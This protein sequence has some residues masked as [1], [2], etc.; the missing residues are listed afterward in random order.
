MNATLAKKNARGMSEVSAQRLQILGRRCQPRLPTAITTTKRQEQVLRVLANKYQ[1]LV[2]QKTAIIHWLKKISSNYIFHVV[3][4]FFRRW[5]STLLSFYS[6]CALAQENN[7]LARLIAREKSWKSWTD[8]IELFVRDGHKWVLV[9]GLTFLCFVSF[10]FF[11][12][13]TFGFAFRKHGACPKN[14]F[15]SIPGQNKNLKLILDVQ[16]LPPRQCL[17]KN[18]LSWKKSPLSSK[19]A[20]PEEPPKT[21]FVPPAE[22]TCMPP[23]ICNISIFISPSLFKCPSWLFLTFG[24]EFSTKNNNKT[25][26]GVFKCFCLSF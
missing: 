16:K 10:V 13:V 26:F 23:A 19:Q 6:A 15:M 12:A 18:L 21:K 14:A 8:I 7:L 17:S 5:F 24:M 22:R 2:A 11:P 1:N 20:N 25:I 4:Q 3:S 9:Q